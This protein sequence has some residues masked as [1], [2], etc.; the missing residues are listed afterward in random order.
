MKMIQIFKIYLSMLRN[1]SKIKMSGKM[2]IVAIM[3]YLILLVILT[4]R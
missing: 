4:F 2:I 1:F 3:K